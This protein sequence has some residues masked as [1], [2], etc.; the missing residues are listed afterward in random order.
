MAGVTATIAAGSV[1]MNSVAPLVA[2]DWLAE[3]LGQGDI[4]IADASWYLPD[5]KRDAAAEFRAKHIPGAVFFDIDAIS[6]HASDLPHMLP[7]PA[8]FSAA[9]R[10]LGIGDSDLVVFYDGAG[11][12]SAPRALWMMRAMGHDRAAVLDGGLP[13]WLSENRPTES[14]TATPAGRSHFTARLRPERVRDFAA[15]RANLDRAAEQV[16][17]ARS[18]GRFRGEEIEPRP[19]VRPGHIPGSANVHYARLVAGDGTLRPVAELRRLFAEE[20]IALDRPVVTSCGSGVTAAIVALGLEIA[21]AKQIAVYDGSW[22]EWGA[23]KDAPLATGT[24]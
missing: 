22:A 23:R 10:R 19:G 2:T 8:E 4:R 7:P 3:R 17:D 6:D 15:M 20:R 18:P 14:G 1:S 12:Y 21:G 24:A 9:M 13:K 5:V 11:I 16:V